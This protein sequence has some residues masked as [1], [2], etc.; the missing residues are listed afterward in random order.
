MV[1]RDPAPDTVADAIKQAFEALGGPQ[2][3][4]TVIRWINEHFPDRWKDSAIGA[5]LYGCQVNNPTAIRHHPWLPRFLYDRGGGE[6]E[7]YDVARHGV[8][9]ELGHPEG[10]SSLVSE[11]LDDLEEIADR[12]QGHSE[13]AYEAHLRDYLAKNIEILENGLSLWP[14]AD[15]K[16]IE[17]PLEGRRI[18][19]LA[20]DRDGVP[21][22][23]ELK[24]SRGHERTLG[25]ALYYRGKLKQM[26]NVPRVRIILVA[27]EIMPELQIASSEVSDV[28][29]FSYALT[30]QVEKLDRKF[31]QN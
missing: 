17:F 19:I 10:Q 22:V 16:P 4:Q 14:E 9:D 13:F 29:L 11:S 18:D 1:R 3:R 23:I 31:P 25:Q 6:L 8:F 2:R 21:V 27:A 15:A 5:H 7:L 12:V 30:M 28:D 20:K 24:L 26:L